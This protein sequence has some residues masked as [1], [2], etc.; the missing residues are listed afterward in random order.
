MALLV[1]ML[2]SGCDA[3]GSKD[4]V[5]PSRP[6]ALG[7]PEWQTGDGKATGAGSAAPVAAASPTPGADEVAPEAQ[8]AVAKVLERF[9]STERVNER[10]RVVD[11][12][13]ADMTLKDINEALKAINSGRRL[14]A[15]VGIALVI[16]Y[17]TRQKEW[18]KIDDAFR[19]F[20]QAVP[21]LRFDP[22]YILEH[23][24]TLMK[25][26]QF[27]K[28]IDKT[29][30]AEKYFQNLAPGQPT[31]EFRARLLECR[32]WSSEGLFR[33]SVAKGADDDE[34]AL[35]R[36]RAVQAWEAYRDLLQPMAEK[37]K[38]IADRVALAED[39]IS[40]FKSRDQ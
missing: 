12:A 9:R 6:R 24:W 32:A 13:L 20:F 17:Y 1:G 22:S 10:A 26:G 30:E 36:Q 28:S 31:L 11:A 23:G 19:Q 40:G 14:E 34:T 4:E 38:S 39:H 7:Q 21:E 35:W 5:P 27:Q 33:E 18:T 2:A 3:F 15:E 25:M 37:D 16:G 8:G 29:W